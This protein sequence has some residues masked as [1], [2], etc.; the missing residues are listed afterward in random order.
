MKE[1]FRRPFCEEGKKTSS[2]DVPGTKAALADVL[3]AGARRAP[4]SFH[5]PGHKGQSFF[6][7][8]G[9]GPVID[10]LPD[11]DI[12]EIPGADNLFVRSGV[13]G[14][15][16]ERWRALYQASACR[17]LVNGSTC[18]LEAAVMAAAR[19]GQPVLLARNCHR[20]VLNGALMA[21]ARPVWLY[22]EEA[23]ERA[24]KPGAAEKAGSSAAAPG[25][26]FNR[27]GAANSAGPSAFSGL[28]SDYP[29]FSRGLTA[30][31]VARALDET[32]DAA[33]VVITR[34]DYYGFLPD[35]TA[36]AAEVHRRGK[37]LIVDQAHGAHLKFMEPILGRRLGAES[38]GADLVVTSIHKTLAG[39]TQSSLLT[40]RPDRISPARLDR[41]LEMVE[42]SSPSYLLMLSL[43][44]AASVLEEEGPSLMRSWLSDLAWFRRAAGEIPGLQALTAPDL[45]PSKL[46]LSM[47][48]LGLTGEGLE[49]A[50][51][52]RGIIP[53]LS[54][55]HLVLGMT[56]IGNVRSD[57]EK[58][59]AALAEIAEG[60]KRAGG[61]PEG[62]DVGP[63][64]GEVPAFGGAG[65][66]PYER[67]GRLERLPV[68]AET[69]RLELELAAGRAAGGS[70]TP[71]PPGVPVVCPG[72]VLSE[73]VIRYLQD[74]LRRGTP[75]AGVDR[76]GRILVGRE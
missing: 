17:L 62:G 63:M 18:G 28:L 13:L 39:F 5:M 75:V 54:D 35:L 66:R 51:E 22:P 15:L 74:L 21:G 3:L 58:L 4:V 44:M 60:A 23:A 64:T 34:P 67:A 57:Y 9:F 36:I 32:P 16:E 69:E 27:P 33:C 50:L 59:A 26:A 24:G 55:R 7:A 53:E 41:A 11:L 20:S 14:D 10:R 29:R 31:A 68:P 19:P 40:F 25:A 56:G 65:W 6:R 1:K 49:A 42:S 43:D 70:L 73:G 38:L 37:V 76:A 52:E 72:E 45:D 2:L 47:A 30:A 46:L 71:Y 48:P 61:L 8:H 12:T